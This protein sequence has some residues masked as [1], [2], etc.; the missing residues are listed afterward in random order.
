[1]NMDINKLKAHLENTPQKYADEDISSLLDNLFWDYIEHNR[2]TCEAIRT[3]LKKVEHS[4][5]KLPF[6]EA[7]DVYTLFFQ[8]CCEDQR[9]AF[10]AGAQTGCRLTL[11][12]TGA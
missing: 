4:L 5:K 7:D 8:I 10:I 11:E 9:L 3:A 2:L 12:L 6:Q 1:M